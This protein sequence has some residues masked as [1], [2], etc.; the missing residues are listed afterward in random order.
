M[1]IIVGLIRSNGCGFCGPAHETW[2]KVVPTLPPDFQTHDLETSEQAAELGKIQSQYPALTFDGTPTFFRIDGAT[3][4]YYEGDR[5]D[6]AALKQWMTGTRTATAA[7]PALAPAKPREKG[8][9]DSRIILSVDASALPP[10]KSASRR[11]RRRAPPAGR[12]RRR[13][14]NRR[15]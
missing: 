9:A 12:T 3:I 1:P 7:A 6:E 10:K 2:K 14:R 15:L 8:W 11:I 13:R 4:S 5:T